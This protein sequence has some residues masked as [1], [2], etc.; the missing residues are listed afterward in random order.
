[1]YFC[2]SKITLPMNR[3]NLPC[4]N[5]SN[6]CSTVVLVLWKFSCVLVVLLSM[7]EYVLSMSEYT[8]EYVFEYVWFEY[9]IMFWVEIRGPCDKLHWICTL[10][11]ALDFALCWV[12]YFLSWNGK[13]LTGIMCSVCWLITCVE[14]IFLLVLLHWI[15]LY[16]LYQGFRREK[17]KGEKRIL[18]L[19]FFKKM[20]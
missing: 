9:A 10:D 18:Q 6:G 3:G 12:C 1:M 13:E 15:E 8:I 19:I 17:W 7:F 20:I 5:R 14:N 4:T 2:T 11:F 16:I